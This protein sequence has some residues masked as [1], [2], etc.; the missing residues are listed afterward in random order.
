[1]TP[2][3]TPLTQQPA[4]NG[5]RGNYR[6]RPHDVQNFYV[7]LKQWRILHAVIDCGGFAE[8]A[9]HLHLS[10]SA[11]SYTIAKLQ[12]Q[13]DVQLLKIEGRKAHLTT[14]GRA[15][16]DRSRRVLK[17]AIELEV[18]ARHLG[19]GWVSEVRL[20]VDQN[21]PSQILMHALRKFG[22]LGVDTH[23]RLTELSMQRT[24]EVLRDLSVD[25]AISPRVPMGFLGEPLLEV[26]YVAVAHPDHSLCALGRGLSAAD[27][28]R[29]IQIGIGSG[30]ELEGGDGTRQMRRWNLS[31]FD[32]VVQAVGEGLGYAWLPRHRVQQFLDQGTLA[33]LPLG[34]RRACKAMLYLI[35][36]HPASASPYAS[37]LAEVL[38]SQVA[39][40]GSAAESAPPR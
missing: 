21:C 13:L 29:H 35:H 20:A 7:S 1:M 12:E 32:T 18:F 11:I 10:Q 28:E 6:S 2:P 37:R 24:E 22:A 9:K 4:R 27:L 15:L 39:M 31:S 33:L 30:N 17:E 14:A 5:Q 38:R 25:L 3:T 36:G 23:V 8:A 26:E 34:E 40:Q 16:L 19:Q